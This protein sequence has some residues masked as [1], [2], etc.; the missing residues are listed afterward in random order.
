[1]KN[2]YKYYY[3]LLIITGDLVHSSACLVLPRILMCIFDD[4]EAKLGK[5]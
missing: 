2:I 1:M 4:I 5:I 3:S